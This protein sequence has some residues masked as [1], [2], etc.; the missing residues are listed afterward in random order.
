MLNQDE[1]EEIINRALAEDIGRGDVTTEALIPHDQRG[2]ACLEIKASGVMAGMEV[3]KEV[4]YRVDPEIEV[5]VLIQDG[6][7]VQALDII[8]RISG[9]IT[10]ILKEPDPLGRRDI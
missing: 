5:E 7:K 2:K 9:R 10:S 1:I 8:A 6:S 3:A 4:F